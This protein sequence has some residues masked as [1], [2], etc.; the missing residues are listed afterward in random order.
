MKDYTKTDAC[1]LLI[2][3]ICKAPR[4]TLTDKTV[5]EILGDPSKA[6]YHK[7]INELTTD[8][9]DRK[10]ILLKQK[11][12]EGNIQFQ[13]NHCDWVHFL[14][15]TQEIHFILKSYKEMGHLFPKI[16]VDGVSVHAKNID[17]RFHYLSQ[18]K[19]KDSAEGVQTHLE[20]L[21]KALVG[22]RRLFIKY[23][24]NDKNKEKTAIEIFPLTLVQYRDDLY[25]VAYKTEMKEENLRHYKVSRIL[26]IIES[27]SGFKYP[28]ESKWNPKEYFKNNSG[29]FVGNEKKAVFRIYNESKKILAE[30][31]FFNSTI[32]NSTKDYDEYQCVYSNVEEFMGF[33]FIYGQDVEVMSDAGLKK[34]FKEKAEKIL[35]RNAS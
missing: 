30:K 8:V 11:D 18:V 3:T 1:L 33:L 26:E 7:L 31:S 27:K 19:I 15:G 9:G 28:N 34:A 22:N 17:R 4:L 5:R 12:S 2:Q 20:A 6:Q 16:D 10:A 29:I 23:K 25:L 32:I 13:L 24:D 14:E 21:I 35:K